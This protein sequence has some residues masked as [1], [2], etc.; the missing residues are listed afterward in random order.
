MTS[1][2]SSYRGLSMIIA[3]LITN[4]IRKGVM[5]NILPH[6]IQMYLI[7]CRLGTLNMLFVIYIYKAV[8]AIHYELLINS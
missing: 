6:N 4:E 7:A 3:A 5:C 8:Q 1:I 2:V